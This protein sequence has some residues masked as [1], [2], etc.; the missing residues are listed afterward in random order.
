MATINTSW[1]QFTDL[2]GEHITCMLKGVGTALTNSLVQ[3]V[4]MYA[5]GS[6]G[7]SSIFAVSA[8]MAVVVIVL[9]QKSLGKLPLS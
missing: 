5:F 8:K 7:I 6:G 9:S 4:E 1:T 2:R 3:A